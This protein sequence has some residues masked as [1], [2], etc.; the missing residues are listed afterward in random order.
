M[1]L[2]DN[3]KALGPWQQWPAFFVEWYKPN[4]SDTW[5]IAMEKAVMA[6]TQHYLTEGHLAAD[7]AQIFHLG[8]DGWRTK[9]ADAGYAARF[10]KAYQ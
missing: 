2:G 8:Y 3:G 7:I 5:I 1:L 10:A 9:G 6:M 4:T